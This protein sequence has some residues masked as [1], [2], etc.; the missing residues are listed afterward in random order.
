MANYNVIVKMTSTLKVNELTHRTIER[1]PGG[2]GEEEQEQ[3][4][5]C[6]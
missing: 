3:G 2:G 1:D 6:Q 4:Q 5:E